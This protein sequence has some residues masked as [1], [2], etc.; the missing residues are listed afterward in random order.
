MRKDVWIHLQEPEAAV[1][2]FRILAPKA[3]MP[4]ARQEADAL[5]QVQTL[6]TD[7]SV[8]TAD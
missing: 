4:P 3:S 1:T 7:P 6:A 5:A 8:D 2:V